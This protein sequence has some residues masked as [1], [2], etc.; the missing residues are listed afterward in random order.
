MN[1]H[2]MFIFLLQ[3]LIAGFQACFLFSLFQANFMI[4]IM[5]KLAKQFRGWYYT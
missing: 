5:I 4:G 1:S 2:M 3:F